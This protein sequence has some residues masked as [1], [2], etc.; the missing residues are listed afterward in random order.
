M[1]NLG[2][3]VM[4][5]ISAT[6]NPE[7][8]FTL[9]EVVVALF[10]MALAMIAGMRTLGGATRVSEA[11][12]LRLAAQWSAVNALDDLRLTR[13]WPPLGVQNFPCVQGR[14]ALVCHQYVSMTPNPLFRRV[15]VS[16]TESGETLVLARVTTVVPIDPA[17]VL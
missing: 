11:V 15:E 3:R 4:M 7:R 12:S 9:I 13:T 1:D 16:V 8:G 17:Q 14:F 2:G 5:P 6:G 10:I